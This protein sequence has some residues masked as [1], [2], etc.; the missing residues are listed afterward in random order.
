MEEE[1]EEEDNSSGNIS[2]NN[3]IEKIHRLNMVIGNNHCLLNYLFKMNSFETLT[4]V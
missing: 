4:C 1:E 3:R 2:G